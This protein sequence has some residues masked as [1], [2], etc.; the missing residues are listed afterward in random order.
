MND[1]S[2]LQATSNVDSVPQQV[3]K[4]SQASPARQVPAANSGKVSSNG[5]VQDLER[6]QLIPKEK[7]DEVVVQLQDYAQSINRSLS[8]SIDDDSGRAV[9]KVLD[10][11]TKET[12]RQFPSEE[13][14]RLISY[15]KEEQTQ[16]E[17]EPG[18]L[19]TDQV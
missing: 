1:L 7:L 16:G 12:I 13:I 10:S 9:V 14:L 15:L 3:A 5:N 11:D 4:A 19:I 2:N 8:F 6:N 17:V 18:L